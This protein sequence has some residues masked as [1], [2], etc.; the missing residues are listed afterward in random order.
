MGLL[1]SLK[2]NDLNDLFINQLED[3]YDAENR[4][5]DALPKMAEASSSQQLKGAFMQHLEQ[6]KGHARRLEQIFRQIGCE[7]KR[8]TCEAMK[9]L[10]ARGRGND[11]CKR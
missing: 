8:E 5:T 1:T 6:T 10:G 11:R 2:F 9:G 4:L 3:L 7:P